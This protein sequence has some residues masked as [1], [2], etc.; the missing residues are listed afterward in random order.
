MKARPVRRPLRQPSRRGFTLIELLVVISIIAVLM[1]LVLPAVQ[2]AREAARRTQ[3]LNNIRGI[4]LA[5]TNFATQKN[6]VLPALDQPISTG[7]PPATLQTVYANWPASLLGYLDRPDVVEALQRQNT[8]ANVQSVLNSVALEVF[9]CPNDTANFK[10]PGGISYAANCGYGTTTKDA[11]TGALSET[12]YPHGTTND[13]TFGTP[14]PNLELQRDTGVFW[15]TNSIA[16]YSTLPAGTSDPFK[17]TLDRVGTRD[18]MAQTIM[19]SEN[20]N[21]RN[22]GGLL[23]N[24]PGNGTQSGLLDV[25]FIV[26]YNEMNITTPTAQ[27]E[28]TNTGVQPLPTLTNSRINANRGLNRGAYPVPSSLHAGV[29]IVSFCD[30]RVKPIADNIN[31]LVYVN[32]VSPGGTR[33]GQFAVSDSD[34]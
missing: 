33:H 25:G 21:A 14:T 10:L 2:S 11:T 22:W 30:G 16:A 24:Y 8:V 28:F 19:L 5:I 31:Q 20:L 23:A 29:V 32:L 9:G 15:R 27:N 6:G 18:G 13:I 34:Y 3:C 12:N 17:M 26:N 4:T 7:I 1:S